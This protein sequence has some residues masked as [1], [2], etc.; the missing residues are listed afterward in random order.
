MIQ[1]VEDFLKN[2][3]PFSVLSPSSLKNL[4]NYITIRYYRQGETIFKAGE[5]PLEYLYIVRKGS[6]ALKI[7]DKEIDLLQEGDTFGYLSLLTGNSPTS[8]AVAERDTILYLIP[9]EIFLKLIEKYPEFQ[10]FFTSSLAERISHTLNFVKSSNE[11]SGFEKLLTLKVKDLK[12]KKVPLVKKSD[13]ILKVAEKMAGSGSSCVIVSNGEKGIITERDII[14]KVVAQ[15]KNQKEVKAQEIMT[16]PLI[17]VDYEDFVFDAI[18]LMAKNN[19]RRVVVKR[20]EEIIGVLEDKDIVSLQTGSFIFLVKEIEKSQSLEELSYLYSLT[21]ELAINL[22]K[23]GIRP[24]YISSVISELNDKFLGKAVRLAIREVGLEPIVPFSLLALGSEGRKEQTLKTDQD[25]ALIYDDTYPS[26][27]VD[28]KEYFKKLGEKITEILLR[29]GFPPCPAGVMVNNPEWNKGKSEWFKT[30]ERWILKP[31]PENTL[32]ASIFFDFRNT[33]GDKTLEEELRNKVFELIERGDLFIAYMLKDALRFR[34]PLGFFGRLKTEEKG[35]DLKKGGIFPI[36]QGIRALALKHK[37]SET[38]TL[39]RM[40][41]LKEKG[42]LYEELYNNLREAFLLLQEL[43]LKSQIEKLQ[44][45]ETLDN[46]VN[47][48]ELTKIERDLLKDAFKVVEEFQ[49]FIETRY[50]S[51][52]PR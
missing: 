29:I 20:G 10:K 21:K 4:L 9:K 26:L 27:D 16:T 47:P 24:D 22:H 30:V 3:Y 8:T 34:P 15:G 42:V 38:N 37:V 46:Y 35:I 28:L 18:L 40:E 50:L 11:I 51:Y 33:F 25:N 48:E 19:I 31:E 45:G 43:R 36:T 17:T 41:K 49:S 32:K 39:Q 2:L 52:I 23:E 44:K 13:S 7:E 6:V 1:D 5:K 12:L 14:K